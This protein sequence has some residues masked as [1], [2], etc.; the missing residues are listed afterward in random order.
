MLKLG[1]KGGAMAGKLEITKSGAMKSVPAKG[2]VSAKSA[3][4]AGAADKAQ[5]APKTSK[6]SRPKRNIVNAE[7]AKVLRDAD[8]GKNLTRYVDEDNL[9]KKLGIKVG[10]ATA[11]DSEC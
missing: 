5:P 11:K 9:F 10:K 1:C 8:A 6:A 7:T 4:E 2:I 3:P